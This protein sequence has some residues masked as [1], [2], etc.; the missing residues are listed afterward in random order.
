MQYLHDLTLFF[1]CSMLTNWWVLLLLWSGSSSTES[2]SCV[3]WPIITHLTLSSPF[4][5]RIL[6]SRGFGGVSER[7]YLVVILPIL[8]LHC[9]CKA[10]VWEWGPYEVWEALV[11]V[12]SSVIKATTSYQ[13]QH[14]AWEQDISAATSPFHIQ[15]GKM[16]STRPFSWCKS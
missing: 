14:T 5:V 9:S 1:L 11:V 16:H 13:A 7:I 8:C 12:M 6:F 2:T 3:I 4:N 10:N 15:S